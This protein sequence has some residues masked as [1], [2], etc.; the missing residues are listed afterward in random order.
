MRFCHV[1]PIRLAAGLLF[2]LAGTLEYLFS[3]PP[4]TAY[5]LTPFV[6]VVQSLHNQF[7]PFGK[8]GFLAPDFFHPLAFALLCMALVPDTPKNRVAIC[9]AWLGIDTLL[10]LAQNVG[11]ELASRLPEWA[12]KIPVMNNIDSVLTSGTFD[13]Q[14][15]LAIACG[16]ATALLIGQLTRKEKQDAI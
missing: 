6:G 10:E 14:D 13:V 11:P 1:H 5:F 9:L 7:D 3:R 15:I 8:L 16:A 2:L 12:E 4:G